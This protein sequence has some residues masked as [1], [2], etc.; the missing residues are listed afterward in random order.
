M[1]EFLWIIAMLSALIGGALDLFGFVLASGAPQEAAAA[2]GA[3]MCAIVPYCIARAAESISANRKR[4]S[5][6]PA[7]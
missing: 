1:I 6:S 7:P 5:G 2:A 4:Q 3:C